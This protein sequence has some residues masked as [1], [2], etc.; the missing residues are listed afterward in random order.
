LA[1]IG[2]HNSLLVA[3]TAEE[4]RKFPDYISLRTFAVS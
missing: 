3:I 1:Q 2:F 4:P